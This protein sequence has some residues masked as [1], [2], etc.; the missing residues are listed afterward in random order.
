VRLGGIELGE[1]GA[2]DGAGEY[3]DRLPDVSEDDA[4]GGCHA[5]DDE[6]KALLAENRSELRAHQPTE[7]AFTRRDTDNDERWTVSGDHLPHAGDELIRTSG[8]SACEAQIPAPMGVGPHGAKA[9]T[10]PGDES[11]S[12]ENGE[13]RIVLM[14]DEREDARRVLGGTG[15]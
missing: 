8:V 3:P 1:E 14:R 7:R 12:V 11:K 5:S 4:G 6:G 15:V 10:A 13:G 2:V 9:D